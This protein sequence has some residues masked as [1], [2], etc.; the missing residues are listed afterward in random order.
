MIH[1]SYGDDLDMTTD[2]EDNHH[3]SPKQ[4]ILSNDKYDVSV[5][6]NVYEI[7]A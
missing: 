4:Q 3:K 7:G 2:E 6:F 5:G 1:E